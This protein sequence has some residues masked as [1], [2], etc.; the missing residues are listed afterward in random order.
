MK[1]GDF[2]R[3][4]VVSTGALMSTTTS[5]QGDTIPGIA[6]AVELVF[7]DLDAEKNRKKMGETSRLKRKEDVKPLSNLKKTDK[8]KSKIN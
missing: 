5:Q 8:K 2:K 1:K 7:N 4:L 6:H 3:V